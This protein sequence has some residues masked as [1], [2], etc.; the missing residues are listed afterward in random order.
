MRL[1][2]ACL[3][4]SALAASAQIPDDVAK[5]ARG[6]IACW[7]GSKYLS[8]KRYDDLAGR[9]DAP[10]TAEQ[11][12]A[13]LREATQM[14]FDHE[15]GDA[16][17][18][19][20][21]ED[22]ARDDMKGLA[23]GV[24]AE[25]EVER[26]VLK[27]GRTLLGCGGLLSR[28]FPEL[29]PASFLGQRVLEPRFGLDSRGNW[30]IAAD[31]IRKADRT[32]IPVPK[33][34]LTGP[35]SGQVDAEGRLVLTGDWARPGK[36]RA[37]ETIALDAVDIANGGTLFVNAD[38]GLRC[39]QATAEYPALREAKKLDPAL[40]AELGWTREKKTPEKTDD[41]AD[42]VG[43]LRAKA[44]A[45]DWPEPFSPDPALARSVREAKDLVDADPAASLL[46]IRF[47]LTYG[48]DLPG[49]ARTDPQAMLALETKVRAFLR[50]G[51]PDDILKANAPFD[52]L[53]AALRHAPDFD[54]PPASATLDN[55]LVR[56]PKA[57]SGWRRWPLLVALHGQYAE[58]E[59]D[60]EIWSRWAD[61][62]G[63]ILVC[64]KYGSAAG[65]K[66]SPDSDAEILGVVKRLCL[67]RNVDPDRIYLTGISMGGALTWRLAQS[68][69]SRW[70]GIAPEIHG[71]RPVDGKYDQLH[72]A[73][74][75]PVFLM[76]GEFD[77]LNTMESRAGADL[78]RSRNTP[79][80]VHEAKL[81]GHDRL[82]WLYPAALDWMLPRRRDA[83]PA[84]VEHRA[85]NAYE[86]ESSWLAIREAAG[87]AWKRRD[88]AFNGA[89]MAG[90]EAAYE[91]GVI[92]LAAVDGKPAAV[93]IF[94]D[95]KFMAKEIEIRG[96]SKP[97]K[98]KPEPSVKFMLERVRS[99]GDREQLYGASIV[100]KIK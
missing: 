15:A 75:T 59:Y 28:R 72:N 18:G 16:W 88:G 22:L 70:A 74:P 38:L 86:G 61:E 53:A 6:D 33:A 60:F 63:Y 1:A 69:P 11:A 50:G 37:R 91:D 82:A 36:K 66:R 44:P 95:G 29:P 12:C 58:P 25:I 20:L 8:A 100:V 35:V 9:L 39:V 41:L 21:Y 77:G 96:G 73:A 48:A 14:A 87:G 78:L 43:P 30:W 67:E 64:P 5:A 94:Q 32:K 89:D 55:A 4:V 17:L 52:T 71:P 45:I 98:W 2:L 76:E 40:A 81:F 92:T 26:I 97:V 51:P 79:I 23:D 62:H 42:I 7:K 34:I 68:Y 47:A 31:L 56:F 99:T 3:F 85:L 13:W 46:R 27:D 65:T 10:M 24:P 54:P 84:R 19:R 80:E 49:L 90:V 83:H 57:Y 93:E